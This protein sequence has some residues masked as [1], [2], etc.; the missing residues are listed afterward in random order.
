[1][2]TV[3]QPGDVLIRRAVPEDAEAIGRVLQ[4]AFSAYRSHYSDQAFRATVI[5]PDQVRQRIVE[6]PMWVALLGEVFVGTVSAV[7]TD[8]GCYV[9]GM[10]VTPAARG[11]EIGWKLLQRI[12]QF[13]RDWRLPVLY[14][15]TTPFLER[16]ISLYKHYGFQRSEGEPT[17]LFGTPL[18]TMTKPLGEVR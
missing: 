17:T 11:R 4:E 2:T 6:G 3:P 7:V 1:M 13:A 10:G 18:F 14:L 15:S 8:E 12:E 9:R 16:A 5:S